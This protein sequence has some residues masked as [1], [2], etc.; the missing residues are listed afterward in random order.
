MRKFTPNL[1]DIM[2]PLQELL[3]KSRQWIWESTQQQAFEQIKKALVSA[4]ILA[5]FDVSRDT[6]LSVDASSYGLGAV[7][8]QRQHS[9]DLQ[10]VVYISRPMTPTEQCYA[11]I[12]KEALAFTWACERLSDYLVGMQF[13][14]HTDHKPLVPLFSTKHLEELPVRV[15]RFRLRMMRFPFTY[16]ERI[17]SFQTPSLE[18]LLLTLS[19][20]TS[21]SNKMPTAT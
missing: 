19:Q 16:L 21:A 17:C 1:A 6:V 14:I 11:Q 7:L 4:P 3:V 9:G 12:E 20:T 18:L 2:R 5:L 13:H 10:P 15:Q 8:L